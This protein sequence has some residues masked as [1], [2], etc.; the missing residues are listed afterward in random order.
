MLKQQITQIHQLKFMENTTMQN[1]SLTNCY[2]CDKQIIKVLNK[3]GVKKIKIKENFREH[4]IELSNNTIM[5]VAVC[6]EC[7]EILMTEAGKEKV[8]IIL[9]KNKLHWSKG[10]KINKGNFD[11]L[12]VINT[13]ITKRKFLK[14]KANK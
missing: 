13:N 12:T 6:K 10:R 14:R 1:Y 3:D 11:K 4:T 2:S 9:A 7:K 8:D 5:R